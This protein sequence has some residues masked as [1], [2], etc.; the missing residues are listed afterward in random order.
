MKP[1]PSYLP[2]YLALLVIALAIA[3]TIEVAY[4]LYTNMVGFRWV[5]FEDEKM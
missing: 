4:K 5:N 1:T 3:K 2:F